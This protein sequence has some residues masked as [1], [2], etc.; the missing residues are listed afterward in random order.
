MIR[1]YAPTIRDRRD[2]PESASVIRQDTLGLDPGQALPGVIDLDAQ[3][4]IIH[5]D[6]HL[7]GLASTLDGVGHQLADQEL[8][9]LNNF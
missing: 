7:Y 9:P 8:G 6:P 1:P 2:Q 3:K 5:V 4:A